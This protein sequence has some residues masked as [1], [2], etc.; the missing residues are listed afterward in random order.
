MTYAQVVTQ[1]KRMSRA[2]KLTLMKVL[3]DTLVDETTITKRKRTLKH[4]YGALRPKS[5]RIPSN[6]QIKK[7]YVNYL[8]DKYK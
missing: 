6:K 3:A 7:E 2:E 8:V 5:G 1:V 4:L